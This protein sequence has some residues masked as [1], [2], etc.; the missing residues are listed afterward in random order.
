M[1][2]NRRRFG[3]S[4]LAKND[5][6]GKGPSL[7]AESPEPEKIRQPRLFRPS[8]L[9]PPPFLCLEGYFMGVA[10]RGRLYLIDFW[11]ARDRLVSFLM[12]SYNPPLFSEVASTG[13]DEIHE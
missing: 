4:Q 3:F 13:L 10:L 7:S 5:H 11:T 12:T 9:S 8:A 1:F 6:P 2:R